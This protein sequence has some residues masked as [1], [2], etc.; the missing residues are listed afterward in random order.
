[1]ATPINPIKTY[2]P[3]QMRHI[4]DFGSYPRITMEKDKRGMLRPKFV[5][6]LSLHFAYINQ[7]INQ[8]YALIGSKYEDSRI[9]A[10]QHNPK[11]RDTMVCM[12]D[13]QEYDV[14][15]ISVNDTDYLSYDLVTI[16]KVTKKV[17]I[18]NG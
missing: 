10:V 18:A 7:T 6:E 4:A 8:K 2:Q 5:K 12:I 13:G 3:Y 11:L 14:L 15:N 17:G 16:K 9:I 1:M